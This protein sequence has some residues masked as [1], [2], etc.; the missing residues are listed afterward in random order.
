[1]WESLSAG[2]EQHG[3]GWLKDKYDVSWQIIPSA[4]GE[5]LNDP[6]PVKSGRV[7]QARLQMNKIDIAKLKQAYE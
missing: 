7:M 5:M 2:G 4:L 1:L 6:D 3:C